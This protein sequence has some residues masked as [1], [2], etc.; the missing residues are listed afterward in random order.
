MKKNNSFADDVLYRNTMLDGQNARQHVLPAH[1]KDK[2]LSYLYDT[3]GHQ[4]RDRAV[5]LVRQRFY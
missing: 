3:L 4:D 2:V 5:S 1:L